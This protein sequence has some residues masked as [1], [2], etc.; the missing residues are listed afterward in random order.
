M[1]KVLI[2]IQG[3]SSFND[4]GEKFIDQMLAGTDPTDV[5]RFSIVHHKE[6]P[7]IEHISYEV[8]VAPVSF[9]ALPLVANFGYCRF[10]FSELSSLQ[11]RCN[12][13]I[14]DKGIDTVWA[15]LNGPMIIP[16]VEHIVKRQNVRVIPQIWDTPEYVINMLHL[17]MAPFSRWDILNRFEFILKNVPLAITISDS[18]GRIYQERYGVKFK[19]M[20]YCP[21]MKTWRETT[22]PRS[23]ASERINIVFAGSLYAWKEWESFLNAVEIRNGSSGH[24]KINVIFMGTLSR[25]SKKRH[26][27]NYFPQLPAEAAADIVNSANIAYLPYWM[28]KNHSL[29]VNTAFPSKLAFYVASGTPILF[30]GPKVSTPT[31]FINRYAVGFNCHSI[32]A[33]DIL[34][35]IDRFAT[36]EFQANYLINREEALQKV[37]HPE[38]MSQIFKEAIGA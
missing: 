24:P 21:P 5:Y 16:I 8:E 18:M 28:S 19:T 38:T 2:L 1:A 35:C 23:T 36:P 12:Q 15:I 6:A 27:V 29:A 7:N 17:Y 9:I 13:I 20:V 4:I 32:D 33:E 31:E 26:W 25:W 34:V 37:F 22:K 14:E 10:M 3:L 30:H 11:S